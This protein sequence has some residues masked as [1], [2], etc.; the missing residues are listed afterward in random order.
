MA[1]KNTPQGQSVRIHD[2]ENLTDA[3]KVIEEYLGASLSRSQVIDAGLSA[4][5]E[6]ITQHEFSAQRIAEGLLVA[7]IGNQ[8]PDEKV[9]V[10]IRARD[11]GGHE[12]IVQIG[13][14]DPE[15]FAIAYSPEPGVEE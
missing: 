3:Q 9:S 5:R 6:K 7:W 4:L 13:A 2:L 12:A 11:D 8:N 1:K 10:W 14:S 15:N